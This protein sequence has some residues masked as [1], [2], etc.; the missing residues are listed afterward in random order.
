MSAEESKLNDAQTA[1]LKS[2][3]HPSVNE[4]EKNI[5]VG[6]SNNLTIRVDRTVKGLRYA[7][8]SKGHSMAEK[9]DLIIFNGAEEA[10]G[11]MGGS[12]WTFKN[13]NWT[14]VIDDVRSCEN[15]DQCGL[16]L[17]L[18]LKS[19]EKDIIRLK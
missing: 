6:R 1:K 3:V 13:G 17:R 14:Y 8:W 19:A 5:L 9:P 10:Q 2:L 7:S 15:E 18:Y 12:T 4:W 11:T 16:F